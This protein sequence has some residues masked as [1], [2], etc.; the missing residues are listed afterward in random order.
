MFEF[1][2]GVLSP[3]RANLR[4]GEDT[5]SLGKRSL[6]LGK[7]GVCLGEGGHLGEGVFT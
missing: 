5:R 2:S 3:R 4:L 7:G 1:L 6:R